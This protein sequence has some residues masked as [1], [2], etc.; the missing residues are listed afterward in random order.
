MIAA[1]VFAVLFAPPPGWQKI[2]DDPAVHVTQWRKDAKPNAPILAVMILQGTTASSKE[3][4]LKALA[5]AKPLGAKLV[6]SAPT[7]LCRGIKGYTTWTTVTVDGQKR[8]RITLVLATPLATYTA[9][10]LRP[11]GTP[12]DSNVMGALASLCPN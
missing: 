9:D 3:V 6:K 11:M 1:L 8:A 12:E 2:T 7:P 10:Y 5:A 4:A